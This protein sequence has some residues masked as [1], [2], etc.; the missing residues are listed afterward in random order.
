M[1]I[2]AAMQPYLIVLPKTSLRQD[3]YMIPS[4]MTCKKPNL[5][6]ESNDSYSSKNGPFT[7]PYKCKFWSISNSQWGPSRTLHASPLSGYHQTVDPLNSKITQKT[8]LSLSQLKWWKK[9]YPSNRWELQKP[10][11]TWFIFI[12]DDD[13]AWE[14]PDAKLQPYNISSFYGRITF[15]W[16][17]RVEICFSH[18][19]MG[20]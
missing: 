8:S 20:A 11:S 3:N 9:Q 7:S 12:N 6:N 18:D 16:Y 10:L 5:K 4:H 2:L 13:E 14:R 1:E 15:Q 19:L 17:E